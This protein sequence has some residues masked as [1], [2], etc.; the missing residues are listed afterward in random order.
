MIRVVE[1]QS[2]VNQTARTAKVVLESSFGPGEFSF[3][4]EE[5]TGSP[6]K[7]AALEY[8]S[9]NGLSKPALGFLTSAPYPVDESGRPYTPEDPSFVASRYRM[10]YTV[11]GN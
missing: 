6:G 9:K 10:E 5:L 11:Q 2:S 3:A 4:W 7:M 8:A 1:E